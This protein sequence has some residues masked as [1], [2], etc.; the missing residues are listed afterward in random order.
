MA[1]DPYELKNLAS[2]PVSKNLLI[3]MNQQ[4]DEQ[5]KATGYK[6]P[7]DADKEGAVT[8]R[9]NAKKGKGKKAEEKE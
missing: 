9:P 3:W 6:V 7:A 1:R 8:E 4:F 5:V 2:E